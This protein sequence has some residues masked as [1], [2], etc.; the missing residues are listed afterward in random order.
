MNSILE[1]FQQNKN[2]IGEV[3]RLAFNFGWISEKTKDEI[4]SR[5]ETEKLTIAVIGQIK[6]GKSTF[7]NSFIFEDDVL[8]TA[9]TPMTAAL[10]LITYGAEKA[11]EAEFY[12][13]DE[14]EELVLTA[15]LNK[16]DYRDDELMLSRIQSA[17]DLVE[18]STRLKGKLDSMLGQKV[19]RSYSDLSKYVSADGDYVCITKMVHIFHPMDCLRGVEIVDTPGFNDPIPSREERTKDILKRADVVI[20]LLGANRPF[21]TNDKTILFENVSKCGIGRVVIAINKY[22]IWLQA[23]KT[24]QPLIDYVFSEFKK[25]LK[26]TDD[27]LIKDAVK[28]SP[29]IAMSAEMALL[30]QLSME[31]INHSE[32][33]KSAWERYSKEIIDNINKEKLWKYSHVENLFASIKSLIEKEKYDILIQKPISRIIAIGST[34]IND[35]KLDITKTKSEIDNLSLPDEDL[36]NKNRVLNRAKRRLERKIDSLG[37]DLD[38]ELNN[39]L[40]KAKNRLEDIVD[41][42]CKRMRQMIDN[43]GTFQSTDV[44]QRQLV[45]EI[46]H[47]ITR[48]LKRET[49]SIALDAE[50]RI[51]NNVSEFFSEA[52]EILREFPPY[53]DFDAY[54]FIKHVSRKIRFDMDDDGVFKVGG[55][56]EEDGFLLSMINFINDLSEKIT[57]LLTLGLFTKIENGLNHNAIVEKLND[58]INE[59]KREFDP[60][61]CLNTIFGQ[62]EIVIETVNKAFIDDLIS[63]MK[64][65]IDEVQA[66]LAD[67]EERLIEVKLKKTEQD[68][69]LKIIEEN[70]NEIKNVIVR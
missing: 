17:R 48:T 70:L 30:S 11:I 8:P 4:I 42:S 37:E 2:K 23:G 34:K 3:S 35:L 51:K 32:I 31:K 29:P 9:I 69:R 10:S 60:S 50:R 39:V 18:K 41:A 66:N 54:E 25:S 49:E 57:N 5:V 36:Q 24:E 13:K 26:E 14:W 21:D 28:N 47:L 58:A 40:R 65:Q 56:V 16:E 45:T 33:F 38:E 64:E 6:C 59:I 19:K 61:D 67:R 20:L 44:I 52:E 46:E 7:L 68:G 12:S 55:E 63:P 15:N 43:W 27:F 62:K 1:D 53:D 22:D